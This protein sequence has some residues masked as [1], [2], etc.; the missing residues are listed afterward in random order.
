MPREPA[1]L[2]VLN[3][4]GEHQTD[5]HA[6]WRAKSGP[7]G[8]NL[9]VNLCFF[10]WLGIDTAILISYKCAAKVLCHSITNRVTIIVPIF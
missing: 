3:L 5:R 6:P 2:V 4:R 1:S 8:P 10:E 7:P 9:E